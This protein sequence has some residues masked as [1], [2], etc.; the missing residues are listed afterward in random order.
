MLPLAPDYSVPVEVT[1]EM[2]NSKSWVKLA[3]TVRDPARR[4]RDIAIDTPLAFG[5]APWL[6][7]FGTD[8]G[9]YGVFRNPTDGVVLTQTVTAAGAE[10]LDHRDVG[11]GPA[12]AL[13]NLGRHAPQM[14]AGWGHVQDAKAAVAFAVEQFGRDRAS[15]RLR[16]MDAA[17]CRSGLR[18]PSR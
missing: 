16:W 2:P 9:T 11:A 1:I 13:R 17:S 4:V 15:I 14:A 5:E 7:D 8:S 12:A 18:R 3:A 10:R 6:W